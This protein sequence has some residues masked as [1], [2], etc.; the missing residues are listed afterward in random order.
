MKLCL[1]EDA[2]FRIG[3]CQITCSLGSLK[4]L[5]LLISSTSNSTG[6]VGYLHML[7]CD[8]SVRE[9]KMMVCGLTR[10]KEVFGGRSGIK[11]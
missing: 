1:K 10:I 3:D 6:S 5:L 8:S 7:V 11:G 2:T 4:V 9:D